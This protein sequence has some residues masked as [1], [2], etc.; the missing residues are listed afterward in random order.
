MYTIT[1]SEDERAE[2]EQFVRRGKANARNIKRAHILLKS[3]EGWG[4][5]RIAETFTYR[6]SDGANTVTG[7]LTIVVRSG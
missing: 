7:S 2:L 4:L 3:A 1:L 5:E 6:I